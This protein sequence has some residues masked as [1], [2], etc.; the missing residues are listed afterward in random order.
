VP[1]VIGRVGTTMGEFGVNISSMVTS[2]G[3]DDG[4][5]DSIMILK[6]DNEVPHAA[7]DKCLE[8]DEIY[9]I[10]IIDL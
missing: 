1:G 7:I 2:S 3:I 10:K 8:L 5:K 4:S 9:E 6:V